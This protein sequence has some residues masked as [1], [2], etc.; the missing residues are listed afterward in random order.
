MFKKKLKSFRAWCEKIEVNK[1]RKLVCTQYV[2]V[3]RWDLTFKSLTFS[4][5]VKSGVARRVWKVMPSIS[6][7]LKVQNVSLVTRLWFDLVER[8][9][10]YEKSRMIFNRH[11]SSEENG[12]CLL[13]VQLSNV[14]KWFFSATAA[15]EN[16]LC[17][18]HFMLFK[19]RFLKFNS[20]LSILLKN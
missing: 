18:L 9:L 5:F 2:Y 6:W 20:F 16:I 19:C 13:V 1:G 7:P 15:S 4:D 17:S 11:Q 12:I 14:F 10:G 3:K 8:R